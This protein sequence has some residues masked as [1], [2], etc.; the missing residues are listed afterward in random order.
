MSMIAD[1]DPNGE[2]CRSGVKFSRRKLLLTGGSYLAL[3]ATTPRAHFLS[4]LSPV[5]PSLNSIEQPL[6]TACLATSRSS[7]PPLLER[8]I[9]KLDPTADVFPTEIYVAEI[10]K[11]FNEW[12]GKLCQSIQARDSIQASLSE[13]LQGSSLQDFETI[14]L[15]S[16]KPLQIERRFFRR[17]ATANREEFLK[18]WSNYIN[19]FATLRVADFEIYGVR[20]AAQSPL[21]VETDIRYDFV[22]VGKDGTNEQRGGSWTI[23]WRR[24]EASRWMAER[25]IASSETRAQLTGPGFA[26]ITAHCL[27]ASS[28]ATAQLARGVDHWRAALDAACGIDVYGNH[29]IAVGDIDGSGFDSFYVCQPSGLPNR[30]FRNRG[31]GTF[32]DVT[33]KAGVGILDGTAS[34]L[35]VDFF[36]RGR[37]DLLVVRSGGPLLFSNLGDGRFET[38]P[39]AFH[40][41]RPP[42]GTFTSAAVADYNRDGLLDVYFCVYSYYQGLNQYQFPSPYYDAQNGPPNF[43]FRNR[44]D[45]TF[46]DV[47]V[48]SGLD[49]NN[50]RFSFAV[51]WCD[52]DNDGWPDLHVANDFGRKNL[53]RNNGDGTFTDLAAKAGVEDYGPG[54]SSCWLDYD[55]DG[56]QDLYVANMWLPE[57]K[58]ITESAPFL[59][60]VSPQVRALYRKHNA[61]NSL[62]R[63]ADKGTF[64]DK[65]SEAGT[66]RG[67]WSWSSSTWDFDNDG[68]T[69]LYVANG[70]VSNTDRFDLQSFFWRQ[71]AQRSADPPGTSA[72]YEMSWNAVNE[73]V[74]SGYSWSGYQRNVFYANNRDGTFSD[75]SGVLG[76]DLR[77]DS[78]AYALSD[79]DHDGRIEFVLKNRTG[80]QLR[81]MRNDLQDVGNSVALRLTG[82]KSNRDAIGAVVTIEEGANRL[83]KFVSAGSGFASQH[84]KELFFGLGK[85]SQPVTATV[86]WPSGIT[87]RYENIPINHRVEINE[88]KTDLKT[89]AWLPTIS[90]P[91]LSLAEIVDPV[92][93]TTMA[94]W[95]IVPLFGPDLKLPDLKGATHQLSAL[96]GQAVLLTF[97]RLD[98]GDSRKQLIDLQKSL[99]D[100]SVGGISVIAVIVNS[101]FDNAVAEALVKSAGITFPVL[102]A[103]ARTLT[104]WNI[105]YRYLFDSRR[106]MNFPMSFLIDR[107][108]A[109]TRVY[110]GT[111]IPQNVVQ[112]WR[113]AP[114][115]AEARFAGAMPYP[116]PYYGNTMSRDYFTYGIAFVEYGYLDEAQAALQ[117]VVDADPGYASAWFNLGTIFL[118][119]KMYP[120]AQRCLREAVRL[121][122]LDADAWNNLGM[123]AGEQQNYDEALEDFQ[124]SAKA[125]PNHLLAVQNMMRIYQFQARP[126]DA[127]KTLEELI[128][129]APS[130][131]DLHLGLAMAFVGQDELSPARLELET[132][133]RIRPDYVDAINNLGAVLLK[134]GDATGALLEFEKCRQLA[135]DFDR[136]VINLGI[137]YKRLG[138]PEKASAVLEEFLTRHPD[139]ADVRKASESLVSK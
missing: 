98:C 74:R 92:A 53:Y 97:F 70:F 113:S 126:A 91:R 137:V 85:T 11:I 128:A 93:D 1:S 36:N 95:L 56:R 39:D 33:E 29:G 61:G 9:A 135:P 28:P 52:Y 119:K 108:G 131:A 57:G 133:I 30:L 43:L 62:F 73:L 112:D 21:R 20:I 102:V 83:T 115:T 116:G 7:Y 8:F 34:A 124:R 38:R 5:S 96:R 6:M 64:E 3:Q 12:S 24:S 105:Q 114:V 23:L 90:K 18:S 130:N 118:N 13:G 121:N 46:E 45:G 40:F 22:G 77:D 78:R 35:F 32:E 49:E 132:A 50:N 81:I 127:Q 55:N 41:A 65:S 134:T 136:A 122:P 60:E 68:Y 54:M 120:D 82:S 58:R 103:D 63:N 76:L 80:P 129:K 66:A 19:L 79:F 2:E 72:D 123:I 44:G 87:T 27:D 125:N 31:D 71:V 4:A 37:Q 51:E 88:G 117:R 94:T 26:E 84:T 139:N 69:D 48:S 67:G 16:G 107:S 138:Q 111:V 100:L 89:S 47:T 25:W 10:G 17:A 104:V 75:V 106:E 99:A 14:V 110:Q 109:I 42:Q 15:R 59:P 101:D 86:R